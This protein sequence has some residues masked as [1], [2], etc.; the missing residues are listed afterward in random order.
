MICQPNSFTSLI[1]SIVSI[2]DSSQK[3]KRTCS[4]SSI[5]GRPP[6][7]SV[8]EMVQALVFHVMQGSGT[9]SEN[10]QRQ[11]GLRM[12]D[13]AL[14]ERRQSL[15]IKPWVDGVASFLG[16]DD[17]YADLPETSYK[18]FRL[19]GIDGTTF[20]CGNT[21]S[22]QKTRTKVKSRRGDSAFFRISCVTLCELSE[23]RPLSIAIGE[24]NESEGALA[25]QIIERLTE[26]DLLIAEALLS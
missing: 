4:Q 14:S 23:H 10:L 11:G 20:N 25:N 5:G 9:F 16:R 15:G 17:K 13:S 1:Q 3:E 22:L 6:K 24:Q 19:V 21:P 2:C 18:G 8:G 7:L 12:S 26:E